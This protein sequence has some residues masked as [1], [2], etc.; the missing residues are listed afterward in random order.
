MTLAHSEVPVTPTNPV[1]LAAAVPPTPENL[2]AAA[3]A[4]YETTV[5][6]AWRACGEP[7]R[8]FMTQAAPEAA[9]L[10]M[11]SDSSGDT[12][13]CS[14]IVSSKSPATSEAPAAQ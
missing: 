1:S 6:K 4:V 9:E 2:G 14:N 12:P 13:N 11:S 7:E 8:D 5:P 10:L 3:R